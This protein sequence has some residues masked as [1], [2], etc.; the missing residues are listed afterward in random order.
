MMRT[1]YYRPNINNLSG[2]VGRAVLA[3]I[4][5]AKSR[6]GMLLKRKLMNVWLAFWR[7]EMMKG[8]IASSADE[9]MI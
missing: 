5:S 3:E 8:Q 9:T 1:I 6:I 4:R 2:K 7:G